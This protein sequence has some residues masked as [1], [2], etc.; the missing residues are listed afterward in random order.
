MSLLRRLFGRTRDDP[1]EGGIAL[2]EA[3]QFAEAIGLLRRALDERA[4]S[5]MASLISFHLRQALVAEGR[6]LL[7]VSRPA[8]AVPLLQE[9][10]TAWAAFADLQFLH[11]AAMGLA[12]DWSGALAS[13]RNA[14]RRNPDYCEARLLE[15][16]ALSQ[17]GRGCEAA[18]SLNKLLESGRRQEHPLPV[19]LARAGGYTEADL[20]ADLPERVARAVEGGR[21]EESV[22][23]AV[24]L[25]RAGNWEEGVGRLHELVEQHPSYADYR[26]KL[27]AALF[28]IGR[29]EAA[30][31][32]VSAAL[33]LNPR[34]RMAALLKALILADNG[35]LESAWRIVR[36]PPVSPTD[37]GTRG[38][39]EL[40]A[41]YLT[42]TVNF[43]TGRLESVEPALVGWGGLARSFPQAELLRAAVAV[44]DGRPTLAAQRLAELTAA[45]PADADYLY[46]HVCMLLEQ[47][48]LDAV[49]KALSGW[50]AAESG[51]PDSRPLLLAAH[52]ALARNHSPQ[53]PDPAAE[54]GLAVA[55][56]LLA[57]R[58]RAQHGD[59]SGC[60]QEL[61]ALVQAEEPTER[62]CLLQ[63]AAAVE[64][65]T[66][67]APAE[68]GLPGAEDPQAAVK[69]PAADWLP[70]PV[71]PEAVVPAVC[72]RCYRL[73]RAEIAEQLVARHARLHPEDLRWSWL[74]LSFW[75]DPIRRWI[76]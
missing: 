70:V 75:L 53:L 47:G 19:A 29:G 4:G 39:E 71:L 64:L 52:L 10:A 40:F 42:A 34:Y 7:S 25:C 32:E 43:L 15:S 33:E 68:S 26:V 31:R 61:A 44:L 57:A 37:E 22:A 51:E 69:A 62:L 72:F 48:E 2:Y 67:E 1:Y 46:Y 18:D 17:L 54:N 11:G 38:H 3:G 24:A 16:C 49:E 21:R 35:Q 59:W 74:A 30:E 60:W 14:L 65:T 27:A 20:P 66:S 6:R 76:G 13:V 12:G 63:A 9:A 41:A 45:W 23:A 56:R 73:E 58:A 50:P 36:Q 55:W 28:Q 5:A 8:A